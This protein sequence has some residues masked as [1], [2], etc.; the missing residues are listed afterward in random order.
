MSYTYLQLAQSLE[1][2]VGK[3]F[4]EWI[5]LVEKDLDRHLETPL[6]QRSLQSKYVIQM[7]AFTVEPLIEDPL[8]KGQGHP[9]GPLCHSVFNLREKDNLSA[10]QND[11]PQSVLCR[12]V[13]LY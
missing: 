10:G 12:E 3:T 9:S 6:M 13:L 8:R 1:E 2:F 7:H 4:N 5:A 11:C